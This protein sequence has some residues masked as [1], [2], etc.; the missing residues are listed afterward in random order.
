MIRILTKARTAGGE[1][2]LVNSNDQ[3]S[4]L[5]LMTKLNQVFKTFDSI[6]DAEGHFSISN[7]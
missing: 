4:Q 3:I 6:T 5:L 7:N 2:V 1:A